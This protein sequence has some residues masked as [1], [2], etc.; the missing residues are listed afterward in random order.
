M[1]KIIVNITLIVL[2]LCLNFGIF[3]VSYKKLACPYLHEAQ[4]VENASPIFSYVLTGF[5]LSAIFTVVITYLVGKK[6]A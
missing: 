5:L 6:N 2:T 1:K 4:R 3:I